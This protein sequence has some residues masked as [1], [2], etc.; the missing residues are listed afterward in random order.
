M[1]SLWEMGIAF[2]VAF[3][4]LGGWLEAPMQFF[5]FL[6]SEEFF[7][8]VLPVLYW[9]VDSRLG[10][11]VGVI[12]LLSGAFNDAFKLAM[13]GPRPYWVSTAV[14]AFSAETSFGIPSGHAQIAAGV[15]G[16]LAAHLRRG[17]VWA[18][19]IFIILMIGISRLYLGV[20][21]PHDVLF[22]WLAG[23]L[24]LWALLRFWDRA[25]AWLTKQSL[26]R[27]IAL[28]FGFSMLLLMGSLLPYLFLQNWPLPA[29]WI[30][31]AQL[32]G[33]DELPHPITLNGILTT[34]GTLFGLFAGLAWMNTQ[35]G[36][37]ARGTTT[38][39]ILRYVLGVLGV[40]ILW[41]GLGVIFPRGD[42]LIPYILRFVRYGL[43]G[44]WVSAG[45]PWLFIKL[46]LANLQQKDSLQI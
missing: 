12:L 20:H 45:A 25:A 27:Q 36:F 31:N 42:E 3:Q 37:N 35:G 7:L 9:S 8:L 24:L 23:M 5:T 17:W 11:R 30:S 39:R 26:G 4:S 13:H 33:V 28:A 10:L 2:I 16:M 15:W 1:E 6:G 29:S 38:Q 14:K 43:V 41:F 22:G 19:A 44:L 18:I 32:A 21:F 34:S 46:R 40:S